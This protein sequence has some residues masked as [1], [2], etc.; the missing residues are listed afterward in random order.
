MLVFQV[1]NRT[2]T[3]AI[4][5]PKLAE[6]KRRTGKGLDDHQT[7]DLAALALRRALERGELGSA[8]WLVNTEPLSELARELAFR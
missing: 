3:V 4:F 7:V 2:I 5:L 1:D 8:P 6:F